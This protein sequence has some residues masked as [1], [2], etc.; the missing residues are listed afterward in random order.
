[1]RAARRLMLATLAASPL[2]ALAQNAG[3]AAG[4][5]RASAAWPSRA[6]QVIVPIAPGG[7][8]DVIGRLLAQHLP[9]QLGQ[10][11][12]V[13]NRGGAGGQ[14]GMRMAAAAAPDGHT[15]AIGNPGAVVINPLF[16][17]NA[18]YEPTDFAYASMLMVAPVVLVV[19]P[20]LPVRTPRELAEHIRRSGGR[21]SFA[22]SGQGQSPDI[23]TRLFLR[24]A[25]LDAEVVPYRGAAPA[26]T[27]LLG[28]VVQ[29]MFDTTT[30]IAHVREGRLRAL[31]I[32][33]PRRSAIL[34]DVPTMDEQGFDGFDVSS[35]Y[36][37]M[38]PKGTPVAILERLSAA[39]AP[40]MARPEVVA[41]I[42]GLNAEPLHS[43]PE[44]AR[45]YVM[46]QAASWRSVIE[47]LGLR[48]E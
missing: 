30:S 36:V 17:R 8:T 33:S 35:W 9:P 48:A 31:A 41:Q 43:S 15:M 46:A 7:P 25:G 45:R 24:K 21:F 22:S 1:M 47:T 3:G 37:A 13:D 5:G 44:E 12:V 23:T 20:D 27:D 6:V 34:P 28:G 32:A 4:G 38:M 19:R 26:V 40:I 39:I 16:Q 14:I 18:G 11:F 29:A 42:E 2:S 10:S